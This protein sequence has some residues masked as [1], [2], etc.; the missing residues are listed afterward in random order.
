[1]DAMEG[2]IDRDRLL[3]VRTAPHGLDAISVEI[4][5]SGPGIDPTRLIS[6]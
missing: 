2:T 4:Q 3:R 6:A 5:D 1:M